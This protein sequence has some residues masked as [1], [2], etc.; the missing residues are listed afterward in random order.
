MLPEALTLGWTHPSAASEAEPVP[1]GESCERLMECAQKHGVYVCAGLV[2]R[3]HK[4]VFNAAVLMIEATTN[5]VNFA[6]GLD[7]LAAGSSAFVFGALFKLS[8]PA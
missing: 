3:A 5:A 6:D 8:M 1:R 4:Q 2:E 7:G